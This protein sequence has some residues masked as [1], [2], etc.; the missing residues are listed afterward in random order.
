MQYGG[1]LISAQ[2]YVYPGKG[3]P[4]LLQIKINIE[5]TVIAGKEE[6]YER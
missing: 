5:V 3:A 2:A 6:L 4:P 1:A